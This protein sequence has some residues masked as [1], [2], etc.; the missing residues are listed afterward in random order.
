MCGVERVGD[1]DAQI[2]HS[3]N[4]QRFARDPV[5]KRLSLQQFHSDEGAPIGI[6]NLVDRADVRVVQGGCSL[7][8][9]LETGEG[10]CVVG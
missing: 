6:V 10:L 4:F 8:L 5:P 7:G 3:F 1:L 9:P 2:E